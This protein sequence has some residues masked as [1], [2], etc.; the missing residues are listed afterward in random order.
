MIKNIFII[1]VVKQRL[2]MCCSP[3]KS[4]LS[5]ASSVYRKEGLGA[6]YRSYTTMLTMNIPFQATHFVVYEWMMETLNPSREY[7]PWKHAVSG[8]M[9]GAV[10][11]TVTM[12]WDVCKTLLNT[13]EANVLNRLNTSRVV[14]IV[15]AFRTVRNLAGYA[16]FFQGLRARVMYQMP[17]TAIAWSTYELFKH[18]LRKSESKSSGS[19]EDTLEDLRAQQSHGGRS[20]GGEGEEKK[21]TRQL[22]DQI[23]T[24]LPRPVLRASAE[25]STELVVRE[26]SFPGYRS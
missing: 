2:Q 8:G 14:G 16:G 12:P 5:C 11:A 26:T 18:L 10:A 17:S 25:P 7:V 21:D 20:R 4:A 19:R 23:V 22:W 13:Q 15:D 6:F 3:Y 9:A 24:D 1:S